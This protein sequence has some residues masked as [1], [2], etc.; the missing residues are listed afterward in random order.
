M[1]VNAWSNGTGPVG[2]SGWYD[3]VWPLGSRFRIADALEAAI[4][5]TPSVPASTNII[6]NRR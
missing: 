5:E 1:L 4:A 3:T 6:S 2:S